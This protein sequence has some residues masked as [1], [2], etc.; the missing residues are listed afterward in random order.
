M[1]VLKVP[2]FRQ[3]TR[4]SDS[5]FDKVIPTGTAGALVDVTDKQSEK[6]EKLNE[7]IETKMAIRIGNTDN[8]YLR[9]KIFPVNSSLLS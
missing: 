2:I 1:E 6:L 3:K 8:Y 7:L 9:T 4:S 5:N